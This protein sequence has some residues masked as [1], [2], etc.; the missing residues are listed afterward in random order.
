M[1]M[2]SIGSNL[3]TDTYSL[4]RASV[5]EK[6]L[7]QQAAKID[8]EN[9]S[10]ADS[11]MGKDIQAYLALVPKGDDGK[12]SFQ[13][14]EDYRDALGDKW[15]TEVMADLEA[16]GVDISKEFLMTY[17]PDTGKVS[18]SGDTED[19]DTI[20]Q[21][22]EDNPDKVEEFRNIIQLGKLTST[23]SSQLSQD[24]MMTNLKQQSLAWWYADNTDPTSWFEGG[25]LLGIGQGSTTAYTGLNIT[26]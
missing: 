24:Q 4:L 5:E 22:F 3:L 12:L 18:V 9:S 14:V 6:Q 25:G 7:Y 21:Y 19:K 17:D 26:V 23:A 10:T 8:Q 13:D 15:D 11:S 2:Q 20:N 16:L 1:T